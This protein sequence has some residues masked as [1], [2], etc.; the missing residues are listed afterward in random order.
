MRQVIAKLGALLA[1]GVIVVACSSSTG[2]GGG[3]KPSM[4]GDGGTC[5]GLQSSDPTCETCLQTSCCDEGTT[6]GNDATCVT[7]FN[8]VAQCADDACAQ[9]CEAANPAGMTDFEAVE[10]CG[11]TSCQTQ[12]SGSVSPDGGTC[13]FVFDSDACTTCFAGSCCSLGNT[14]AANAECVA[15]ESCVGSCAS[16]DTDCET[17]CATQHPNGTADLGAVGDCLQGACSVACGFL[18]ADGGVTCGGF[19][20]DDA[21][22]ETCLTTTCCAQGAACNGNPACLQLFTCQQ[23]CDPSDTACLQSCANQNAGGVTDYSADQAC[24]ASCGCADGGTAPADATGP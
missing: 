4:T 8:C 19:S 5:G 14:C 21:C 17:T 23:T 9:D 7:L 3:S 2:S 20:S 6:C 11:T 1:A 10:T 12:C 24:L 18:T 16:G 13:G 15:L 22:T